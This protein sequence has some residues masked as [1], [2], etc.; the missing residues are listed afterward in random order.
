[1]SNKYATSAKVIGTR[2]GVVPDSQRRRRRSKPEA[3]TQV[4]GGPIGSQ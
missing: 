3:Y 2:V 1:V 4:A